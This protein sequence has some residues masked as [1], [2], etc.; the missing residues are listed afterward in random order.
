MAAWHQGRVVKKLKPKNRR[1]GFTHDAKLGVNRATCAACT[2]L[3]G[4]SREP[5]QA[6]AHL[7]GSRFL[8]ASISPFISQVKTLNLTLLKPQQL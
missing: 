7:L 3:P 6:M 4:P 1:D 5:N 2:F 8:L